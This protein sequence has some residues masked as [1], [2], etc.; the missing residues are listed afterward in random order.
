VAHVSIDVEAP[1]DVVWR[2]LSDTT[3]YGE[4]VV[5]TKEVVHA[6][7]GWPKPGAHLEYAL[8]I[9]PVS[10]GDRTFVV[11][12]ERPRLLVLRAEFRRLGAAMIR[13]EL[14]PHGQ[15][16]HVV[17]DEAPVEGVVETVH[18]SI[19]DTALEQRNSVALGRLKALAE[20]R[21]ATEAT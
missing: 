10:V 19:S 8:G 16:T 12:A 5:G 1:P 4:W 15:A 3:A 7:E 21:A 9:G 13:L 11:E 17:M 14:E 20:A 6:D 2:V 18:T